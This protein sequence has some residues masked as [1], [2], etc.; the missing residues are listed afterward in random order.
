MRFGETSIP[1]CSIIDID[2]FSDERGF[3]ARTWCERE[4][5]EAG[6]PTQLVQCSMSRNLVRGTLRGL[7]F[8]R[9][10]SREGKIVRCCRGAIVDVVLDIR[11]ESEQFLKHVMIE[12]TAESGRAVYIPPGCAHGF[13]TLVDDCDVHY[14]MTDIYAPDLGAGIRWND[15]MLGIGWPVEEPIMND[16]DRQYPDMDRGWLESLDWA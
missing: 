15:P 2:A 14:Q 8:Q 1:H 6:L 4:F 13:Q 11:P 10:P 5:A 12:L 7:H 3:F 9:P 16:R